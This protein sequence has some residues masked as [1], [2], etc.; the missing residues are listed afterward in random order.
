[1]QSER[2]E[3]QKKYREYVEFAHKYGKLTQADKRIIS[4]TLANLK[5]AW[6]ESYLRYKRI[7][8]KVVSSRTNDLT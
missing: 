7:V 5:Q 8:S 6:F 1:M 2:E 4:P 3:A